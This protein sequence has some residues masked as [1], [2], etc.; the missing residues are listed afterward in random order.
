M[1][2][3][4][5]WNPQDANRDWRTGDVRPG[6]LLQPLTMAF[7]VLDE[8]KMLERLVTYV[9]DRPKEFDLTTVQVPA[10]FKLETWL[11]Q[12]VKHASPALLRWLMSISDE[13]E[14]RKAHPPQEPA[15]WRR[16]ST[17]EC[18]SRLQ[19]TQPLPR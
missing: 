17:T 8:P 3:V 14:T 10:L 6:E 19:R 11:K 4:E 5:R 9:L 1:S 2:A 12:N 13:L 15:D 18:H 7:L 16:D